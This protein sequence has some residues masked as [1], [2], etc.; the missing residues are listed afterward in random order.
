MLHGSLKYA[1]MQSVSSSRI[2]RS[3]RSSSAVRRL[4]VSLYSCYGCLHP[5]WRS[6]LRSFVQK[7]RLLAACMRLAPKTNQPTVR[8][9]ECISAVKTL[10]LCV[11][12]LQS[13][14]A[15]AANGEGGKLVK[16]CLIKPPFS[17]A[18]VEIP[19]AAQTKVHCQNC[20][21]ARQPSPSRKVNW[22]KADGCARQSSINS[23][24][25][26]EPGGGAGT[27]PLAD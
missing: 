18:G 21:L 15:T 2:S 25:P 24:S 11:L 9:H 17:P 27:T 3:R 14:W 23:R 4:S 12:F 26:L 22:L 13:P 7:R 1:R 19:L 10:A 5:N 16:T 20:S 6:L 8:E